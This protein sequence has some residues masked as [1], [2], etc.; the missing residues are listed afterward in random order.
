MRCPTGNSSTSIEIDAF[1]FESIMTVNLKRSVA[2]DDDAAGNKTVMKS[3]K[4]DYNFVPK[5]NSRHKVTLSSEGNK[6]K[7]KRD[8]K[9]AIHD[10]GA[11]ILSVMKTIKDTVFPVPKGNLR[12]IRNSTAANSYNVMM[13]RRNSFGWKHYLLNQNI[14]KHTKSTRTRR[15]K[16]NRKR[17][18][19]K[20][21]NEWKPN[22]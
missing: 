4:K 3:S 13:N 22:R 20:R 7:D 9:D 5:I 18:S 15:K 10:S 21:F 12:G 17:S 8:I 1:R 16:R 14:M 6:T 19:K 2:E 11:S